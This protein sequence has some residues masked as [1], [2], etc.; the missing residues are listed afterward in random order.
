MTEGETERLLEV[1]I[2]GG[3]RRVRGP[4]TLADL[5]RELGLPGGRGVAVERNSRIVKRGD[6]AATR[7]E[8]GDRLEIVT[9]VGGG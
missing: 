5:L 4:L 1:R 9:L 2:N 3:I 7:I 6:W 8:D